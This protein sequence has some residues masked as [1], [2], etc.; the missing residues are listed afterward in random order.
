MTEQ[1]NA[2]GG[3]TAPDDYSTTIGWILAI[4]FIL[5]GLWLLLMDHVLTY[6]AILLILVVV[7]VFPAIYLAYRGNR[8]DVQIERLEKEFDL[9]G[10]VK[11]NE[12][13]KVAD[14]YNQVYSPRQFW[15]YI[16]LIMVL[17][18]ALLM[19]FGANQKPELAKMLALSTVPAKLEPTTSPV[20]TTPA[21]R[22]AG[23]DC[24]GCRARCACRDCVGCR[25]GSACWDRVGN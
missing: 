21:D 24:V 16:G 10:L 22:S 18:V 15:L 8:Q 3:P 23:R 14:L 7:G 13:Y 17:S 9:L 1:Y 12:K 5:V 20:S 25:A 11:S 6:L 19:A 2:K 4:V